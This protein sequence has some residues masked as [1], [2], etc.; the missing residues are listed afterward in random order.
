MRTDSASSELPEFV[1]RFDRPRPLRRLFARAVIGAIDSGWIGRTPL[2]MH[3]VVCGFPRG[4]TTLMSLMLQ[5]AYKRAKAFRK[6]RAAIRAA[7]L[8]DRNH[9]LMISK[10]PDDIFYLDRLRAIYAHRRPSVRFLLMMR[11]P[12]AVLTSVHS[13]AKDRYYVSPERWRATYDRVQAN[14]E[15]EDCLVVRFE[16][17][18][19]SIEG[20]QRAIQTFIGEEPD[21]PFDRYVDNVPQGFR[22]TALNGV[23]PLEAQAATKWRHPR[24]APRLRSL[25]SELPELPDILIQLGY[26]RDTAWVNEY[27]T[28]SGDMPLTR[29]AL[30]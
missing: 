8:T 9:A 24:H 16:D 2:R 1:R 29:E 3:L 6:E 25:L 28:Q 10:R 26:E 12:R 11:D 5:V 22:S 21:V 27:L 17:M 19:T 18:I 4:G 13:S 23:R 15:K 7:Y 14:R 20:V 30:R